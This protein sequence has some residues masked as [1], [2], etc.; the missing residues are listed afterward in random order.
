AI[1][2]W[3]AMKVKVWSPVAHIVIDG[4]W[5]R[6][7]DHLSAAAHAGGWF[8]SAD[9]KAE[10]N[11]MRMNGT[12]TVTVEVDTTL[13]NADKLQ[14]QLDKRTDVVFQKFMDEAQKVIFDPPAF[15]EKPAEASGGFLGLG[16]GGALKLRRDQTHLHLHYDEHREIAY[17][18]DWNISGQ[19]EGLYDEIKK[20]PDAEKKYFQTIDV[21]DWD[22]VVMRTVKPVVNWPDRAHAWVG[23]P[24][25]FLS[26]Q[27]GYPNANGEIQWDGHVFSPSD[28]VDSIWTTKTA[29]KQAT[30][31]ANAPANWKPDMTYLKRQIHF[32]EPPNDT[33]YPFARV[34]IERNVVDLDP[35]PSGYGTLVNDINLEVRVDN[36]GALSVGPIFLNVDLET[37]KQMVEV[38]FKALGQDLDGNERAPIRFEWSFT[39][40]TEPRFWMLFTG[41]P[42]FVPKFQYQV[43]VLVK[44]SI[45]TKGQEWL[46]PWV[47][48]SGS[49]PLMI[50]VPTPTD[51]GVTTKAYVPGLVTHAPGAPPPKS[52]PTGGPP[53]PGK[54]KAAPARQPADV[55]GWYVGPGGSRAVPATKTEEPAFASQSISSGL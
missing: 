12:I 6:I 24:V 14:E 45:F 16:G 8:W 55:A 26:A 32:T 10:F 18:Q 42:A 21:G 46:G 49:G 43:H 47:D 41:N 28:P 22:R 15:T 9:I 35:D 39:D 30:D 44:G 34:Q 13:P 17:L 29:M 53:P 37:T 20:N 50:S 51:P 23:E 38:Q 7:Q 31:V 19:L 33:E 27:V 54:G 25:A 5:D 48:A 40:Q 1:T 4:E 52:L 36:V 11:S 3:Q 2:V